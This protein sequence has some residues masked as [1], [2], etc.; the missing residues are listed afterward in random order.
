[1]ALMIVMSG[2]ASARSAR[3]HGPIRGIIPNREAHGSHGSHGGGGGTN[4]SSQN[5]IFHGGPVLSG[6]TAYAIFWAPSGYSFPSGYESLI[7]RYLKDDSVDTSKDLTSNVYY[8]ATQ[9]S[10]LS[11]A[12][13][14]GGSYTDTTQFTNDCR[15]RA[16]AICVSDAQIA[17]E[18]NNLVTGGTVPSGSNYIYFVFTPPGVGSCYSRG[19]CSFTQFCAYHS[20]TGN[21]LYANMPYA[22]TSPAACDSGYQPNGNPADATINVLSHEHNETITDPFGTA[23]YNSSGYENG[24]LCAWNFGTMTG[25]GASA[26]NQTI[27]GDHYALQQEWS[28]KSS[29]CVLQGY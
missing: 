24:D 26:Y 9:Y 27:N 19:S 28:N 10:G 20:N 8:A 6:N 2:S 21:L 22:D 15:D 12:T 4:T 1:M 3:T 23:W 11:A 7:E 17:R 25:S 18:L 13:N 5:L 29:G 14:V 16:T